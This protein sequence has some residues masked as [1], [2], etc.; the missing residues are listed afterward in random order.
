MFKENKDKSNFPM[1][2]EYAATL[3]TNGDMTG[4][5]FAWT[6]ALQHAR[7]PENQHWA[8]SRADFC[9]TWARRY[10]GAKAA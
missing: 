4:A 8:Q 9:E 6:V 7:K 3:E 10:Q 5:A 2:A 1:H